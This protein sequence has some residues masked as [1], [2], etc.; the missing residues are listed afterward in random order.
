LPAGYY[1]WHNYK[2]WKTAIK[3]GTTNNNFDGLMMGWNTQYAVG[4]WVGY[5]TRNKPL[6]GAMEL[7][8][9][10][11]TRGFMTQ[12]LDSLHKTPEN[13]VE[14]AGM[15]HQAGFVVRSHVGIG[16]V[17]P[18][19]ATELFPSWYKPKATSSQSSTIDKVSNKLATNCTPAAAKQT[20]GGNAAPNAFSV[21]NYYPPGSNGSASSSAANTA[22]SDDI[23]NCSDSPPTIS[24]TATDN[25]NGTATLAAFVS[26]GTHKLND[27]QYAQYP[28][29][30]TFNVNGQDVGSKAANDPQDNVSISY[31]VPSTGSFTVTA[32]V[33]D[34]VLYS[35]TDTTTANFTLP[36]STTPPA[37][38]PPGNGNGNGNGGGHGGG[39]TVPIV[40]GHP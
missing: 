6:T 28:G 11:L 16:S 17:E 5:H 3:T 21:D 4:A 30:V 33:T 12:A 31:T 29:T 13:W 38:T 7:S 26:A 23:H 14:P 34:S 10:P 2:G 37:T 8:T 25:N 27:P 39:P 9:A 40:G 35:A 32:T 1:K 18:S 20:V 22:S 15:Q 36:A 19:P 24:V